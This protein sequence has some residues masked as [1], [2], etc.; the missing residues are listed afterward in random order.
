MSL[1]KLIGV[2]CLLAVVMIGNGIFRE[3][4]LLESF[5]RRNADIFSAVLGIALILGI[6]RPFLKPLAGRSA[7]ELAVISVA[8]VAMTLVFEFVFGHWVDGKSWSELL[9]N[10]AIWRG[11]LWPLVLA[12]LAV[13]P[14]IW[15][16]R[17]SESRV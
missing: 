9:G 14:F 2:W 13:A 6:T 4:L 7:K 10:Y 12:S 3:S 8:W 5:G 11:R 15:A 16:R 1:I 17:G